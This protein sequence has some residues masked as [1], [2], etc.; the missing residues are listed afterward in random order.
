MFD[1]IIRNGNI[2]DGT[3]SRMFLGDVGIVGDKI[4]KIGDLHGDHSKEEVDAQGKIVSPGFIDVNNHS[5]TYWQIF[6]SP[7][8]ESLLRQGVTTIIGGNCGS[9]LAP[10]MSPRSIETVQKWADIKKVNVDWFGMGEFL[11]FLENKGM[12]LNFATLTG[13]GT[14][15]RGIL[16]NETRNLSPK[17]FNFC[18]RVLD[19]SMKEGSLGMSL[20]LVYAHSRVA[21]TEELSKLAKVVKKRDG[22]CTVHLREEGRKIQEA[23][24]ELIMIA[25]NSGVRMH[26]SHLKVMGEKN[27]S[28]M[29]EA[30]SAIEHANSL[31]V[32]ITFDVYP[33]AFTSSVIYTLLPSWA[34]EGGKKMM[35][36]RLRNESIRKR[37]VAEMRKSD[38]DWNKAEIS[39]SPLNKTL[40]RKKITKIARSQDKSIEDAV[41]DMLLACEGRMIVNL[42]VLSEENVRRAVCHPFSFISSNG[43]GYD[44][45]HKLTGENVHPRSFGTFPKFFVQYA[46]DSKLL[47]WEEAVRKVT[48][49]P[50]K[51]FGIKKR[52]LIKEGHYSDIVVFDRE[53]LNS[54]SVKENP[55]QY[56]SGIDYV[57]VNGKAAFFEGK[58]TG[59]KSG[60][61]LRK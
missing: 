29:E 1:L 34:T 45:G 5:D 51:K 58:S 27:W 17:E 12:P 23:I 9:S 54:F 21:S 57:F 2:I 16:E 37:I 47:S 20:G 56:P 40:A 22:I 41:L 11:R 32:D 26:I 50:A 42:D 6:L 60:E 35:L 43:A 3:G 14:L 30:I 31:G 55:Y 24:E 33:Y 15:R 25:Q 18:E 28:K 59:I 61:I 46:R 19:T 36:G 49:A 7:G 44:L 10:L 52:G 38:L 4:S 13:H 8:Q 53:K 39:I 48:G